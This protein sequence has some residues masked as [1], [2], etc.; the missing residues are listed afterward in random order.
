VSKYE[1][2]A[3][4][5]A[6][7]GISRLPRIE[8]SDRP[9]IGPIVTGII[10]TCRCVLAISRSLVYFT[11]AI[12]HVHP[13]TTSTD[14]PAAS[15]GVGGRA[16]GHSPARCP[17]LMA[18][19]LLQSRSLI[20][21]PFCDVSC[22]LPPAVSIDRWG[23]GIG[24]EWRRG[25][26]VIAPPPLHPTGDPTPITLVKG[27]YSGEIESLSRDRGLSTLDPGMRFPGN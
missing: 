5:F 21:Q 10:A 27:T 25:R 26:P 18:I 23:P 19:A 15:A 22:A 24:R 7:K 11:A 13:P 3:L 16:D 17:G 1:Q 8:T 20:P 9:T 12:L 4:I 14:C 6:G 2:V